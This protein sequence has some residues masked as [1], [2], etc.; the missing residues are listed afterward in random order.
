MLHSWHRASLYVMSVIVTFPA[1]GKRPDDERGARR[2]PV[3]EAGLLGRVQP[4]ALAPRLLYLRPP[5]AF[6]DE[7]PR[8]IEPP[9]GRPAAA[10]TPCLPLSRQIAASIAGQAGSEHPGTGSPRR[11]LRR[12]RCRWRDAGPRS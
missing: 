8:A 10:R 1:P 3:P 6:H 2:H 4:R 7:L 12:A 9:G 5:G 11:Q